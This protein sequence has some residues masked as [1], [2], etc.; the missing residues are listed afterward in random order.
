VRKKR[1]SSVV[2]AAPTAVTAAPCNEKRTGSRR[3][4][5]MANLDKPMF[6]W[7]DGTDR[8]FHVH[9]DID[10]ERW[11]CNSPYC[12]AMNRNPPTKGG[13]EPVATGMEPWKGR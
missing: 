5:K 13:K 8:P 10:G 1:S 7:S 3:K 6:V 4:K 11:K 9:T 12:E 2:V